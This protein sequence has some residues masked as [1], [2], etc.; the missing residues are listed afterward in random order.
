MLEKRDHSHHDQYFIQKV[1]NRMVEIQG[2]VAQAVN[3]LLCTAP[4]L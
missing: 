1:E 4:F 3:K 2:A